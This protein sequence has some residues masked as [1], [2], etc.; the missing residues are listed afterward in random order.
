MSLVIVQ[1]NLAELACCARVLHS[2]LLRDALISLFFHEL[3][4]PTALATLPNSFYT[5]RLSPP[6]GPKD[7]CLTGRVKT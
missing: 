1:T 5:F 3:S 4:P 6:K 7:I 2:A